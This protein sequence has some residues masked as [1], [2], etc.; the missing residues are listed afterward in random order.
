M[1][2]MTFEL[3]VDGVKRWEKVTRYGGGLGLR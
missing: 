3:V 1:W 2:T